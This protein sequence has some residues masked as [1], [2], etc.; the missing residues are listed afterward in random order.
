METNQAVIPRNVHEAQGEGR[1]GPVIA[2]GR[3]EGRVGWAQ[4]QLLT[5]GFCRQM[6]SLIPP[7]RETSDR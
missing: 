7:C 2:A 3:T 6:Q 5:G 4:C 1:S